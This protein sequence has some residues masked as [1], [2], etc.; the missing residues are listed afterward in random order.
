[1]VH[2]LKSEFAGQIRFLVA[3]ITTPEG[4][5]FAQLH[6]VSNITLLF[7][8]PDGTRLATLTGLQEPDYLRRAFTRAFKLK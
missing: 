5:A 4:R 3:D 1:M 8:S 6:G 7:F 2:S